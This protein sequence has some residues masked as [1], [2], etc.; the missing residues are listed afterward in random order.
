[1]NL[2][3]RPPI[4]CNKIY[5]FSV[6]LFLQIFRSILIITIY[7]FQNL[8]QPHTAQPLPEYKTSRIEKN[9]FILTH[10][11]MFKSC[12][13]LVIL[14]ATFYVAVI[15]PYNAAFPAA[16]P[17][18]KPTIVTDVIVETLFFCG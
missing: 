6:K 16:N 4:I 3:C 17:K 12:W 9:R 18:N 8:L 15:V 7:L 1:M 5:I 10:Y 11:G 14:L 13:D 2:L